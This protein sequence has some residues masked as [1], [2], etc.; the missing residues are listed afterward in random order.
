MNYNVGVIGLGYVGLPLATAF[1]GKYQ[2]IGYDQSIQ[3]ISELKSGFDNTNEV[4]RCRFE[5]TNLTFTAEA[6]DLQNCNVY[7]ITVPTPIDKS[8]KPDL[9]AL[10][11]ASINVGN[12]ITTGDI[13][14]YESTVY[15]GCTR[16]FCIPLLEKSSGLK[17]G[18]DFFVGYSPERINPGDKKYTFE[19]ITKVASGCCAESRDKIV[20]LYSSIVNAEIHAAESIEVAEAAK[21][22]ENTQRDVNIALMNELKCI[23]DILDIDIF[24]VLK[25][26]NTKWNFLNFT[27]GL[28]GG[29]CIGVDPYYLAHCSLKAGHV[30][31]LILGGRAINEAVPEIEVRK[32]VQ[33]LSKKIDKSL[34]QCNVLVLGAAFKDNCPD[35]RNSKA[36][37]VIYELKKYGMQVEVF[38][39]VIN[40]EAFKL[41]YPDICLVNAISKRYDSGFLAVAHEKFHET[42]AVAEFAANVQFFYNYKNMEL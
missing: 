9:S 1:S 17:L 14:I 4:A 28:V 8:K 16:D 31:Q 30:P 36:V 24:E 25:A 40:Q 41:Q 22:I 42:P 20:D 19:N 34:R 6:T 2:V 33:N 23:F 13:V 35:I 18:N 27:P 29:H 37:D 38:D 32:F 7:I 3:R 15:P 26:A 10:E 39:P 5:N 12:L 11:E 21:I